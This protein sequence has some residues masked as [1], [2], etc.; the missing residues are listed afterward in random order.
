LGESHTK[1]L[2]SGD[3]NFYVN[4]DHVT[5]VYADQLEVAQDQVLENLNQL[6]FLPN[7]GSIN[8]EAIVEI[9]GSLAEALFQS[10]EDAQIS[11]ASISITEDELIFNKQV[12][13]AE[14]STSS[15]FL[16]ANP[17]DAMA[18]LSRLPG[19]AQMYYGMCGAM[20]QLTKAGLK[21]S[22]A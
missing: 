7:Q 9:Y 6:R 17:P 16:A 3:L 22:L 8:S 15:Q 12:T 11:M 4:A 13:F 21:M 14:D 10:L 2:L 19:G 18:D 5:E 20:K 1:S